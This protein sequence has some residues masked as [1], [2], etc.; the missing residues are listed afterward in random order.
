V[1]PT[2]ILEMVY[3]L[4]Y[5]KRGIMDRSGVIDYHLSEL[6]IALDKEHPSHCMPDLRPEDQI[7]LD[8]GCGVGQFFLASDMSGRVAIGVDIDPVAIEYG[9]LSYGRQINFI[10]AGAEKIPIPNG[11]VDLVVSRVSIPYTNIPR[12]VGEIGRV[13]R[14]GGRLWMVLHTKA[15]VMD[16][17]NAALKNK[18]IKNSVKQFY[19][20][21]NGYIFYLTG[22]VFPFFTKGY[23]SWQDERRILRLMKEM[24]FSASLEI[25]RGK[26][27]LSAEKIPRQEQG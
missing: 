14:D 20:L 7:V 24:G 15:M 26:K 16:R 4:N 1:F 23:E 2:E 22:K 27:I 13:L 11:V 17:L 3:R 9:I 25:I 12:A 10:L 21:I 8:V 19:V 5:D 18:E 6:R